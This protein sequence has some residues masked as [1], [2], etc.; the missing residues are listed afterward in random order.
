MT[1]EEKINKKDLF[2]HIKESCIRD[3]FYVTKML[4]SAFGRNA[5][6][7]IV[8][9]AIYILILFPLLTSVFHI[10]TGVA[11]VLVTFFIIMYYTVISIYRKIVKQVKD[12]GNAVKKNE[13]GL[14]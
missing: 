1:D 11:Y 4:L 10:P 7:T 8:R 14:T 2:N 5:V 12:N 13:G 9:I 6:D 3:P